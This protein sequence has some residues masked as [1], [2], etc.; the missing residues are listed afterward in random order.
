ML[1]LRFPGTVLVA[2][3]LEWLSPAGVRSAPPS[4]D[5][6]VM[7]AVMLIMIASYINQLA[8]SLTSPLTIRV[9]LA[10]GP[11]LMFQLVEGR[12]SGSP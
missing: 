1:A 12:L 8:I 7:M 11:V 10:S 3:A 2:A 4:L 6:L 9:V 5:T